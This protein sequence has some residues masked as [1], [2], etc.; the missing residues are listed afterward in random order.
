MVS[1][2]GILTL[3]AAID[4][5]LQPGK[6]GGSRHYAIEMDLIADSRALKR[7]SICCFEDFLLKYDNDDGFPT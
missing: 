3:F 5:I 6:D 2:S 1:F 7:S 4:K